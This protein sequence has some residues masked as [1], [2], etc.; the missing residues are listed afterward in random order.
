MLV[1]TD[2]NPHFY[3]VVY[4]SFP[5][6]TSGVKAFDQKE[7]VGDI[8][9]SFKMF[10]VKDPKTSS[11][12]GKVGHK[13]LP[14]IAPG[15][16]GSVDLSEATKS[17]GVI[18]Q[19]QLRI[20][21][22]PAGRDVTDDGRA[23]GSGGSESF[24]FSLDS[25]NTACTLTRRID[26][27]IASQAVKI[28]IDGVTVGNMTSGGTSK[29]GVFED[30]VLNLPPASTKG[31]KQ[32]IIKAE[33][34]SS[35]L[36]INS[37]T[38][39]LHCTTSSSSGWA[40]AGYGP[41]SAAAGE[42]TL[43]D[44]IDV[45]PSNPHS[46]STH[47]YAIT[48]QTWQGVRSHKYAA[49]GAHDDKKSSQLLNGVLLSIEFDGKRSVANVPLGSFFGTSISKK[50][51]KTVLL[52]VDTMTP[53]GAFVL[54]F[55]MPYTSTAKLILSNNS[56]TK[57]TPTISWRTSSACASGSPGKD[58]GYFSAQHRRSPTTP[59]VPWPILSTTGPGI[60]YGLTH[61]FRG[62]ILPPSNDLEFLEGDL[63]VYTD[64]TSPPS[65]G[66]NSSHLTMSGTGTEDFYESGWYF[67]DTFADASSNNAVTYEMP[68]VGLSGA[69]K[70]NADVGC[71]GRCLD[72]HRFMLSDSMSFGEE[73]ISF[74]IEHG[75]VGNNIQAEY[76]STAFYYA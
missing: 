41:D 62:S 55:P 33:Y 50:S 8:V 19:L 6:G 30:V 61:T 27:T 56:T 20:P 73:G 16:S 24:T 18:T 48:N 66:L 65:D 42:Y 37:F 76:E 17:C 43:M 13:A 12:G 5:E 47:A 67:T 54:N 35:S 68:L 63:Q 45:G 46:E 21:E 9:N 29:E 14:S 28:S 38:Y 7:D 75:P 39:A 32:I 40:D 64:V 72:A 4:R 1:T 51:V 36:D 25:A 71:V 74:N 53:N 49:D 10:G 11:K 15:S 59:G 22:I 52:S 69:V 44:Y 31:K 23:F 70:Q 3:H 34:I 58:Y 57:I 60:S 2:N 26:A